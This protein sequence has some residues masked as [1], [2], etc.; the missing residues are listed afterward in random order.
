MGRLMCNLWKFQDFS[1]N[2]I[3]REI[4]FWESRSSKIVDFSILGALNFV[5]LV[6]LS[7]QKVQ[8]FTKSKLQTI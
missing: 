5:I 7:L 4:N 3:L 6:H 8:K 2:Q 1:T